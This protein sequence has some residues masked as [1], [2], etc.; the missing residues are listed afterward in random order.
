MP[1]PGPQTP[2]RE[3]AAARQRLAELEDFLE[4]A[5]EGL[6]MVGPDGTILWANQAELEM[7]GYRRDEYLG[8]KIQEF[9]VDGE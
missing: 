5:A 1:A 6:H 2:E 4:R 8:H 9:H 3:L 7:L